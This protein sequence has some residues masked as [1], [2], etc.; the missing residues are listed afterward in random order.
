[1]KTIVLDKT[2]LENTISAAAEIIRAGGMVVLPFDT[3]YGIVCDPTNNEAIERISNLK[4]RNP[5]K[6]MG[7]VA[8][9]VLE[10]QEIAIISPKAEEFIMERT[11]GKYTFIVKEKEGNNI[12][13]L[14]KRGE[15]IGIRI[16]DSQLVLGLAHAVGGFLA[17]TSANKSGMGNAYSVSEVLFQFSSDETKKIDLIID[18]GELE[19]SPASD[20]WNLSG[21][22]F[23]KIERS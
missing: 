17:Q 10:L 16:P 2:N 3:V 9:S 6:T 20:L 7:L 4:S 14:C 15:T 11:P 18:G 1:M 12:S 19:I 23:Q 22:T 13:N 5:E 8:Y 21:E